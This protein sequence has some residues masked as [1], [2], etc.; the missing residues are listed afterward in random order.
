MCPS[1][2]VPS[3]T[4]VHVDHWMPRTSHSCAVQIALVAECACV[5]TI[6]SSFYPS[7]LPSSHV[8]KPTTWTLSPKC[9]SH[10]EAPLTERLDLT[11][12]LRPSTDVGNLGPIISAV[13]AKAAGKIS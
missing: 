6:S 5:V 3:V 2:P 10:V 7:N 8:W 9:A 4:S 11:L 1:T 13:S 12:S